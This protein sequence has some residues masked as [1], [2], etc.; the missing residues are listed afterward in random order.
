MA[1]A[2]VNGIASP[3]RDD[4]RRVQGRGARKRGRR[5]G[6]ARRLLA[7][8]GGLVVVSVVL[9]GVAWW[10]LFLRPAADVA[11]GLPVQVEIAEGSSTAEIAEEL[12]GIGVVDNANMFRLR[13][14][15]TGL[16]SE[17]RHGVYDLYTG[18]E[19]EEVLET[20]AAGPP[21]DYVTVTIPEGFT[22]EQ[23]A[24][25]LEEQAGLSSAEFMTVTSEQAGRFDHD[26]LRFNPTDSLEGYLFPKTYRIAEGTTVDEMV[27]IMLDQF[28]RETG[29]ID[30]TYVTQ[31]GLTPHDWVT[32]ASM[33]EREVRVP[34]ERPLVSSV[35]YNRLVRDM[36]LEIDA[37]IE[38]IL[39]GTRPR[40]LNSHLEID[41]PYNTYMYKGLPPTPI[42][43]P[44]LAALEAAAEPAATNYLYYVLTSPDGAHTFTE[45]YDEFLEAKERSREVVP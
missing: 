34:D 40:L 13:A 31:L 3:G 22:L 44:G 2:P 29:D 37:T 41:S 33:I 38:Y 8:L 16:D 36:R 5:A 10:A 11:P 15:Q 21:I 39:P 1:D 19:Y 12:A 17:L 42:A 14:T 7:L 28:E 20:L 6:R 43:S 35:I 32:V 27:N 26:F 25:R 23:M 4:E 30:L 45:T 18:M 9:A 24:V